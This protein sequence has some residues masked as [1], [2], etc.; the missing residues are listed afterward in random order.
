MKVTQSITFHHEVDGRHYSLVFPVPA[1]LGE[2]YDVAAAVCAEFL[3]KLRE[4]Q[5][6]T[7]APKEEVDN[8]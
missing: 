2:C 1:P 7:E 8:G 4:Q 3:K 6:K 5:E